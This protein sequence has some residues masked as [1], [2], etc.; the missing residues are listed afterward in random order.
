MASSERR[1]RPIRTVLL[2]LL[3]FFALDTAL[4]RSGLYARILLP[5]SIPAKFVYAIASEAARVPDPARDVLLI[6][7][8]KIAVGF[9]VDDHAQDTLRYIVNGPPGTELRWWKYQ[10]EMMDPR[11]DRYRAI[12]IPVYGYLAR[13]ELYLYDSNGYSLTNEI[14]GATALAPLLP[15]HEWAQFLQSYDDPAQRFRVLRML[16]FSSN[17]YSSDISDLVFYPALRLQTLQARDAVI[18]GLRFGAPGSPWNVKELQFADDMRAVTGWPEHFE[19]SHRR[20]TQRLLLPPADP[21]ASARRYAIYAATW[22]QAIM[23]MYR[24]SKTHVIFVPITAYVAPLPAIRPNPGAVDIRSLVR[25]TDNAT[26]L[27]EAPYDALARP[28]F[29]E[30]ALHFNREG[31]KRFTDLLTRQ[32]ADVLSGA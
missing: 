2:S 27:D 11:H 25:K 7:N 6:G 16:L 4:F 8:S 31:Q 26:F 23:D 24:G 5:T 21:E 32:V 13:P 10:L 22:M 30:D 14:N 29:F 3:V 15:L 1:T 19:D 17:A 9:S 18:A 28:E 12:V 20:A